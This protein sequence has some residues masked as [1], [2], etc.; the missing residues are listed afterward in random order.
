MFAG[1]N[2]KILKDDIACP[3]ASQVI[4]WMRGCF[5][6][7]DK[8]YV[9]QMFKCVRTLL[10]IFTSLNNKFCSNKNKTIDIEIFFSFLSISHMA[11]LQIFC[12]SQVRYC[13]TLHLV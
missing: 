12:I 11:T 6:A 7:F 13:A 1:L 9:S 2:L 4:K 8:K 10:L 3:G 5:D